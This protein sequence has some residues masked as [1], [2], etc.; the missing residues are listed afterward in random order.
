MSR[1]EIAKFVPLLVFLFFANACEGPEGPLGPEGRQGPPGPTGPIG[2]EGPPGPPFTVSVSDG[3]EGIQAAIGNLPQQ[4]GQVIVQ[5]GSYFCPEPIVIDRDK[6]D[7]RGQG[8]ATVLH[9][10]DGANSP[11]LVLGQTDPSPTVTRSNIHVSDLV[12]D[13]NRENQTNECWG[14]PCETHP[15]RNNGIT[16]RRVSDVL[17]ERVTVFGAR[18]GGLVSEL[19]CQRLT[20]SDFTSFDN[21]FDGLAGYE[22]EDSR[23]SG[24]YLFNNC[25]AGL[26]FDS[27]FDNNLINDVLILRDGT[28]RCEAPLSDGTVGIFMRSSR[29]NSLHG[30]QIRNMREH[31]VFL[32]QVDADPTTAASGNT[33]S[34]MVI[35]GSGGAGL[36]ANDASVVNTLVVESQFIGNAGGCISEVVEG[37]VQVVGVVCR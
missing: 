11:V 36:R 20:V 3:C 35:S 26:S 29:D 19:G 7:L 6:V 13:G 14:G 9:L 16:V 8:P 30:L 21:H 37:Q 17:I 2:P 24:L 23:F 25:A 5:A 34:S 22:T 32:A 31:G 12:I 15:I 27:R 1:P 10:V 33:F 4:G 18:S 28:S